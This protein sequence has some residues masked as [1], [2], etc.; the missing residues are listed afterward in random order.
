MAAKVLL[1]LRHDTEEKM[2]CTT[3]AYKLTIE[4]EKNYYPCDIFLINPKKWKFNVLNFLGDQISKNR[5]IF[6]VHK[7]EDICSFYDRV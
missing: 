2:G 4:D 1:W 5:K 3:C 6:G 7:E